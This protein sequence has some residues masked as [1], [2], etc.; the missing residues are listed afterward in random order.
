M[1]FDIN[2]FSPHLHEGILLFALRILSELF[3]W[4]VLG[5][6]RKYRYKGQSLPGE[7]LERNKG[8]IPVMKFWSA[9]KLDILFKKSV[10]GWEHSVSGQL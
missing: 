9:R 3:G 2:F 8:L 4:F 10:A 1:G 6:E 7:I 5:E